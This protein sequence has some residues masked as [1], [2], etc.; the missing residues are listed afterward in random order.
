VGIVVA[1]V[2]EPSAWSMI[3]VGGVT[4]LGIMLRKKHWIERFHLKKLMAT[5]ASVAAKLRWR[6][7]SVFTYLNNNFTQMASSPQAESILFPTVS[8]KSTIRMLSTTAVA[9]CLASCAAQEVTPVA[10]SQSTDD[11][12]T[13]AEID[14]Q[15]K[16]NQLAAVA[17][18]QKSKGVQEANAAKVAASVVFSAWIALSIDLSH[19]EQIQMRALADRNE[20]LQRLKK[21]KECP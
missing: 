2:P 17:L 15:I 14:Q 3:A 13:C 7:I 16:S 18:L 10:I 4:L 21:K 19:A 8:R 20:E 11:Q 12:L 5:V 1:S 9:F 6:C